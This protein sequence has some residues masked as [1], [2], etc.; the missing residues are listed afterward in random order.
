M[1][2]LVIRI[3]SLVALSLA[4]ATAA[5]AASARAVFERYGLIGTFVIDCRPLSPQNAYLYFRAIDGGRV[6][7]ELWVS[8]QL[9]QY[10]YVIDHAQALGRDEITTSMASEQQRLNL[11]YRVEG[12]RLRTF[13]S[14]REGGAAHRHRRRIGGEQSA[15]AV[16]QQVS[17]EAGMAIARFM[18]GLILFGAVAAIVVP[19]VWA[20]ATADCNQD[21][22][23]DRKIQGCTESIRRHPQQAL[24]YSRRGLAYASKGEHDRAIADYTKALELN[25]KLA[26]ARYN[27]ARAHFFRGDYDRAIAD[28]TKAIE[29]HARD[30]EAYTNR[31]TALDRKGEVDRAIADATR[32][33]AINPV[34]F[35]AYV[36][37]SVA[38]ARRGEHDG[39]IADATKAIE[40]NPNIAPAYHSRGIAYSSKR[41][42]DRAIADYTKAIAFNPA[43]FQA[44]FYRGIVHELKADKRSAAADH[45]LA[46]TIEPSH[47]GAR[48]ALRRLGVTP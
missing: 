48:D 17:V 9:R 22:D 31:A 8:P 11:V 38:Y 10:A 1:S 29:N 40:L 5:Q 26:A 6:G 14:V 30:A 44:Y 43:F 21:R 23:L 25:P 36:N 32:A 47:M 15:D 33:I 45:R 3:A 20:D 37:R 27:R 13:E 35:E 12:R 41:E 34:F 18:T 2:N 7:I 4:T 16:V 24:A 28:F 39:A 19:A 42:H 46:L